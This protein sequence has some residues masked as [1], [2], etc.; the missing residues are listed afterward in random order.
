MKFYTPKVFE[1]KP[2][3]MGFD[4]G[5]VVVIV[6][7]VLAFLFTVF[8][9]FWVSL[10]FPI[11]AIVYVSIQNKFPEEGAMIRFIKYQFEEKSFSFRK[12]PKDMIIKK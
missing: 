8:V 10:L 9:H 4:L 12:L 1:K 5:A 6:G 11:I 7:A 3:I 2:I